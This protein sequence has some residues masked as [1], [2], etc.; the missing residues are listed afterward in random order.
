[1]DTA[2]PQTIPAEPPL[3]DGCALSLDGG[4]FFHLMERLHLSPESTT[5]RALLMVSLLAFTWVPFVMLGVGEGLFTGRWDP[6]LTHSE[7]HVRTLFAL[8]ILLLAEL[9]LRRSAAAVSRRV[10]DDDLLSPERLPVW[11]AVLKRLRAVVNFRLFE[12][13][14][15]AFAFGVVMAAYLE[16]LPSWLLR[17]LTPTLHQAGGFWKTATLAT[18]WYV[19]VA[20]PLLLLMIGRWLFR[21]TLWGRL[22]WRLC[23]LKPRLRPAHAD[24]AAGLAFLCVP[25]LALRYF[26]LALAATIASVWYDEIARGAAQPATFSVDLLLFLGLTLALVAL[27]YAVFTPTLTHG[28]HDGIL[29]YTSLM[30]RFLD[31]F[32]ARW[33]SDKPPD[34]LDTSDFSS[35]ADLGTSHEVV[36]EMRPTLLSADDLKALLATAVLPFLVLLVM[37]SES[38][39]DLV[40]RIVTRIVGL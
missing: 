25:V 35:L 16:Y 38:A 6:L 39:A 15:L 18:W 21:W 30:S 37:H 40:Q 19:L 5:R 12:Y 1:M 9:E 2:R 31:H 26:V 23:Q 7:V 29:L 27:P 10:V 17:W 4:P 34:P 36:T 14:F 11:L 8:P 20:Q 13:L 3:E 28:K 22:L 33:L 24:R 32:E